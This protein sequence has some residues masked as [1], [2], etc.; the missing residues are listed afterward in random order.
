MAII[1]IALEKIR[2][3]PYQPKTRLEI[4]PEEAKKGADSIMRQGMILTPV[5][6]RTGMF[7]EMGDGW[8]RLLWHKYLVDHGHTEFQTIRFDERELTDQQM[9][10]LI[11]EAN[12]ERRDLSAIEEAE[13]YV[14]YIKDFNITQDSL[15]KKFGI[16]QG[17][18]ANTMRLLELP[19]NVKAKVISQEITPTHARQLLRLNKSPKLQEDFL[20][21]TV[22]RG[23]SVTQ[24]DVEINRKLYDMSQPLSNFSGRRNPEFDVKGCDGCEKTALIAD[25]WG[26][27]KKENR[28]LDPVCWDKKQAAAIKAKDDAVRKQAEKAID[29]GKVKIF[30]EKTLNYDKRATLNNLQELDNPAE[31][32]TCKKTGLYKYTSSSGAPERVCLDPGCYRAKKTKRTK[33]KNKTDRE[34]EKALS[35]RVG[36]IC[37]KTNKNRYGCLVISARYMVKHMSSSARDSIAALFPDLPKYSNGKLDPDGIRAKL[38]GMPEPKVIQLLSA[39]VLSSVRYGEAW[40]QYSTA[41]PKPAL[42]D[43]S[44][45]ENTYETKLTE[46]KTFQEANCTG[47]KNAKPTLISTAEECCAHTYE[48]QLTPEG[49]C[50]NSPHKD[51]LLGKE[52]PEKKPAAEKKKASAKKAN[53]LE[54]T[55]IPI[56]AGVRLCEDVPATE[57]KNCNLATE[58]HTIDM[59]F[60]V[61]SQSASDGVSFHKVCVKD[62]RAQEKKKPVPVKKPAAVK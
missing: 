43:V 25:P 33:D 22:K 3:N 56:P 15:A 19:D 14:K 6:R 40:S 21:E 57:C 37:E 24:L 13:F 36:E 53:I 38:I 49:V 59:K 17:E 32:K 26:D 44:I 28:C 2:P 18:V 42:V 9:A 1:N 50:K 58:D 16:S 48:R 30:T 31:C 34:K 47:C 5:G 12:K 35:V 29:G 8:Q 11:I 27:H 60:K 55:S 39:L 61:P 52:K 45:L 41:L 23:L 62:Y 10:D 46:L 20:S 51:K 7:F 4:T 54:S